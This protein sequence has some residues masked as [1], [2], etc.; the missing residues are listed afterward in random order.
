MVMVVVM[1]KQQAR[2][3]NFLFFLGLDDIGQINMKK[4]LNF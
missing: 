4:E 2:V 1:E 3:N